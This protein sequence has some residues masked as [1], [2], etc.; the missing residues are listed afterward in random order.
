MRILIVT[1]YFEPEV[2][3]P[4]VRWAAVS[5]VLRQRGHDVEVVTSLP[6]YPTGRVFEPYRRRLVMTELR[7]GM[8]VHRSWLLPAQG[9]GARRVLGYLT[10]AMFMPLALRRARPPD[11]MIVESPPL[12]TAV[13]AL[14][15]GRRW[16]CPVVLVVADLWPDS[17]VDLGVVK[18]GR[19]LGL[20]ERVERA[21]YSRVQGVAAVTEG[22]KARLEGAKRVPRGRISFLP[23]GVDVEQFHPDREQAPIPGLVLDGRPLFVYPGALGLFHDLDVVVE[24]MSRLRD[25]RP[26]IQFAFVGDGSDRRRVERLSTERRVDTITFLDPVQPD[27]IARLLP[28]VTAGVVTLADSPVTRGARPSKMFPIMGSGRPV[29]FCGAGEAADL[30]RAAGCGIVVQPGDAEGLASAMVELADNPALRQELGANGRRY[31]ESRLSWPALVDNWIDQVAPL[32]S[33]NRARAAGGRPG[34]PRDEERR[35]QGMI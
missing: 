2:G 25:R 35:D 34:G 29:L 11:L 17:L 7:N 13:P 15:F 3:A 12:T 33:V 32:V 1:D 10:S 30:V 14:W 4:P 28:A 20:L 27:A 23:N 22:I 16:R 5:R 18:P 24:A 8:R 31:A 9:Q 19:L 21:I 26:D 6:N